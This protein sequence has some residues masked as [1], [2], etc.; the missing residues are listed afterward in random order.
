M[1]TTTLR[2]SGV[3]RPDH[4]SGLQ[5]W[6]D[7]ATISGVADGG[8]ITTWP[9]RGP[10]NHDATASGTPTWHENVVNGK[11]V[12]RLDGVTD[13][14]T[15][16][17]FSYDRTALTVFAVYRP[18]SVT[19]EG[20]VF[21]HWS[22]PSEQRAWRMGFDAGG[23][24]EV[25]FS[26]DGT[27]STKK[28][29]FSENASRSEFGVY[30]FTFEGSALTTFTNGLENNPFVS[31]DTSMS[32]VHDST[33]S[34]SIGAMPAGG[35]PANADAAECIMYDRA[36]SKGERK[37]VENYLRNKYNISTFNP[38][39][40]TGLEAWYASDQVPDLSSSAAVVTWWDMRKP[41]L[42]SSLISHWEF[43]GDAKDLSAN[44]NDGTS[45]S[46][47]LT[48][49][50]NGTSNAAYNFDGANSKIDVADDASIQDIWSGGATIAAWIKP[51]SDGEN[52]NGRILDKGQWTWLLINDTG[53][54]T[55][56]RFIHS[57]SGDDGTWHT[58]QV[59]PNDTWSHVAVTF[60]KDNI[61]NLPKLYLDGVEQTIA[62]ITDPTV[63]FDSDAG[64]GLVI[65]NLTAQTRTFD[66]DID[67]VRLFNRILTSEEIF[68]L[69]NTNIHNQYQGSTS[70]QPGWN[71]GVQN[72]R[73]VVRF[74]YANGEYLRYAP[75][76]N[77]TALTI[78]AA[79]RNVTTDVDRHHIASEW[80]ASSNREW[81]LRSNGGVDQ[82]L[83]S[84]SPDGEIADAKSF[85]SST[86][87]DAVIVLSHTG[88]EASMRRNGSDVGSQTVALFDGSASF[89]VGAV[90]GAEQFDGDICELIVYNRALSTA[91]IKVVE[92]YLNSK[93]A[94]Y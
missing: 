62:E 93:W 51:A 61:N 9:D 43:D 28:V 72:S 41:E 14:L 2:K 82:F 1:F 25:Q 49:D 19:N 6:F 24:L 94:L 29:Y 59:I 70:A 86:V 83:Y 85:T 3:F 44:A 55:R 31:Q 18:T 36:L 32:S 38:T 17:D 76:L 16:S 40:L 52:D 10:A 87:G 20:V 12:V 60:D 50:R 56:L 45:T 90:N 13:Y 23:E 5:L 88:S 79:V 53:T 65:G 11:P 34:L 4:L 68:T 69:A 48:T 89:D 74:T 26:S 7:A 46:A 63:S 64:S 57:A 21:A 81:L 67:D 91:D 35:S 8:T 39:V 54:H 15:I 37:Q 73:P 33:G 30:G 22:Q 42:Q 58:S 27:T 47:T 84:V 66:G 80:D 71:D 77:L 92:N 78:F 75:G